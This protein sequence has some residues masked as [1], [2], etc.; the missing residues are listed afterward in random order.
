MM[1]GV[2][3]RAN[4]LYGSGEDEG[5]GAYTTGVYNRWGIQQVGYTTGA[6]TT[7]G[8]YHVPI[9]QVG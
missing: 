5:P 8:V 2:T 6:C 4:T 9:Q 1:I 7:G 3:A